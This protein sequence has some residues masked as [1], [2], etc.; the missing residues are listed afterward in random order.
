MVTIK[1]ML[2]GN[3]LVGK[4][5]L[6]VCLTT[7]TF[8]RDSVPT[9]FDTVSTQVTVDERMVIL[10]LW[11]TAPQEEHRISIRQFYYPQTDIFI[12]C[13]SICDPGSFDHVWNDWYPEVKRHRPNVPVLLVGTKKDLRHD[14]ATVLSLLKRELAPV[15]YQ[16]GASL[17]RKIKAVK[18]VECSALLCEGVVEVFEEATRA[19]LHRNHRKR[20]KSCVLT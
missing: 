11:D 1:V 4:T 19:V 20:T 12:I 13:F 10:N 14:P 3:E 2:L 9:V 5:S 18:Y 17:A 7:G 15:S 16:Q 6:I 8:P